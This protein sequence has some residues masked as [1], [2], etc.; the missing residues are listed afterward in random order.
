MAAELCSL[1][2]HDRAVLNSEPA[3]F[4]EV[5]IVV[6][7]EEAGFLALPAPRNRK[8][9]ALRLC[10]RLFLRLAAE[11]ERDAVELR[12]IDLR[13][14]VRLVLRRIDTAAEQQSSPM[15]DNARVMPGRELVSARA[16]CEGE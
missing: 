4:E 14:H 5:A 11:R 6:A 1:L 13:E 3:T 16:V 2:V 15:L 12:G 9:G 8:P 10:P 7:G